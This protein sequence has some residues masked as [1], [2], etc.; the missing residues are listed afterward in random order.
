MRVV[1]KFTIQPY[2]YTLCLRLEVRT[3]K[4]L[5]EESSIRFR[6]ISP[7]PVE[8]LDAVAV[9]IVDEEPLGA[10][11]V[12]GFIDMYS[13]RFNV[14]TCRLD[15]AHMETEVAGT[16]RIGLVLPKQ[17]QISAAEVEPES[18]EIESSGR[19]NFSQPE[20][21]PVETPC[22]GH[23]GDEDAAMIDMSHEQLGHGIS[24][25]EGEGWKRLG[26]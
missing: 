4:I 12:D 19:G 6:A 18:H 8:Y 7:C 17:M 2:S 1:E 26:D 11:N 5:N 9:R 24:S 15:V 23:I 25:V 22:C 20:L 21:V 14:R 16:N 3:R 13:L 10:G